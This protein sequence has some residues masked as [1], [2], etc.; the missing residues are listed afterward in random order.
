MPK[1]A[2][3]GQEFDLDEEGFLQEPERWTKEIAEE[4]AKKEATSH[5]M[6]EDHWKVVNYIRNYYVEYDIA[7]PIRM[8]VKAT[9][10]SLDKINELFPNGPAKGACKIAGLAKPTGCQ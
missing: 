2:I 7:P 3:L 1:I 8:L 9:G 10:L 5:P 6:T 4:F